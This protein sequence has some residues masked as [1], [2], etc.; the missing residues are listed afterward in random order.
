MKILIAISDSFCAN[1][2]KGQGGYLVGQ[3]HQVVVVSGEGPEIDNLEIAEPV[4]V[5]RIPFSREISPINDLR[6]LIR[7]I[8]LVRREKPDLINAGNPKTGFLFSLAH[9]FFWKIPLVFTLR[10]LRSDTLTGLKKYVVKLTEKITCALAN[11]VIAISPSLKEHAI[12]NHI[13]SRKKCLV[14]S[15]GSSNGIDINHYKTSDDIKIKSDEIIKKY[16]I[17]IDSFKLVFV[18]RVTKDKGII[19]LLEAFKYCLSANANLRLIIA[20]PIEMQD[21]IPDEYYKLIEE[22]P[23]IHYIGKQIDVRPVYELGDALVLY[24]HREGFGN[25][26]IEASNMGLPT[27]VADIPG[28]KD[29]TEDEFTGLLVKPKDALELGKAIMRLYSDRNLARSYGNNGRRRVSEYFSNTIIWEKQLQLYT[30]LNSS[31]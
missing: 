11:K 4:K 13:V 6:D 29:T 24:S 9:I 19:E 1:F 18:G 12:Q 3:N 23:K 16:G 17:A 7:I 2:I 20:G 31:I 26:V 30:Q 14:L 25:V 15:K 21:P 28:L 22:H 27:I 8:I 5:V 10:G